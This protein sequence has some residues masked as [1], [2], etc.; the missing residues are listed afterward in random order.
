MLRNSE[1]PSIYAAFSAVVITMGVSGPSFLIPH[2]IKIHTSQ[3]A[4]AEHFGL[5]NQKIVWQ[6]YTFQFK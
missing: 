1:M 2:V 3:E 4:I 5:L 6:I